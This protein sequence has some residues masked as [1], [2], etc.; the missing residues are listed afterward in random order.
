MDYVP[1]GR[2]GLKVSRLFLGCGNFG[3]VGSAAAFFGKGESQEEADRLMDI[4]YDMGINVF[5]TANAYGG[6]RSESMVGA[7]LAQ[8]GSAV[9]DQVLL[10]T[11]VFNRM[12]EGPNDWGLSRRHIQQQ[13]EGS[14]RRLGVEAID[15]YM[16]HD[17][18]ETTPMEETLKV[19]DDLV[20]Q[21]KIRYIGASNVPAWLTAKS[22]WISDKYGL[23]RFEWIQNFYNLI[24][25]G[26]EREMLP[27]CLDQGLGYTPFGPLCGGFLTGAYRPDTPYPSGTRMTERP[28]PYRRYEN[29]TVWKGL[30]R[31]SAMAETRGCT[32]AALA[33]AWLAQHPHVTAPVIG[34]A[35]PEHFDAVLSG[36]EITLDDNEKAALNALFPPV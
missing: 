34:P 4:A 28:E 11:K 2:T 24:E 27:L 14:L 13:V 33:M 19:L 16:I 31:F 35:R 22:L 1:L 32:P 3:G 21:G 12:G 17:V 10:C 23:A 6:G 18:D 25:R 30:E 26:D 5:D 20:R 8:R 9:R 15:M 36:L 29:D 7:W